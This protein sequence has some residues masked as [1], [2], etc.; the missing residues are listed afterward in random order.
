MRTKLKKARM[1]VVTLL[2]AV[3][4]VGAHFHMIGLASG[5]TIAMAL[6]NFLV[7]LFLE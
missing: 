2:C 1:P 6:V 5:C 7:W 4:V 3:A